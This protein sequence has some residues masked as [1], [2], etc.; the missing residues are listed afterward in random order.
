MRRSDLFAAVLF[1]VFSNLF[2]PADAGV[3]N[4]QEK[5]DQGSALQ[6]EDLVGGL[7]G[8]PE[9]FGLTLG[10]PDDVGRTRTF[11]TVSS[12]GPDDYGRIRHIHVFEKGLVA[13]WN[14]ISH[15]MSQR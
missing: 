14:A 2:S 11:E 3:H 9:D 15:L 6:V 1:L 10:S 7:R 12:G 8:N 13:I 5:R 4:H